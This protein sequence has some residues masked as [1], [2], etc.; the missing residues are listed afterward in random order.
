MA[1]QLTAAGSGK[2]VATLR[3]GVGQGVALILE[4]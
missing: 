4:Q 1:H 3:I 2:G